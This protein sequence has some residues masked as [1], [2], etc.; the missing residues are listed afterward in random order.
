LLAGE[1]FAA[2]ADGLS[3]AARLRS[4]A[5]DDLGSADAVAQVR[6][7]LIGRFNASNLL[8]VIGVALC[9][10]VPLETACACCATLQAPPGRMQR[11]VA[12]DAAVDASAGAVPAPLAIVDYAHTPDALDQA[13]RALLPLAAQRHGQ[14]WVV[15]GAGGE[16][17]AGK[18]SAM[19]EVAARLAHR[20]VLTSD[21][22]RAEDPTRIIEQIAQGARAV[23]GAGAPVARL[24]DRAA[25]IAHA[26]QRAAP[27]DVV[28][29]A[30][31]G[32]EAVQE[33]RGRRRPF[34]DL[35]HAAA[36]LAARK[37]KDQQP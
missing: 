17:D 16:R 28:L 5:G 24:V 29:I 1:A 32:H 26:L 37:H 34:S 13:I 21:N 12:A 19:G 35:A 18:R 9:A 22:P 36:A 14:L 15:F 3:F 6:T 10:G 23:G 8:G 30:G 33:T 20:V 25:A 4:V 27:S 31:K 11:V 2:S 7:G